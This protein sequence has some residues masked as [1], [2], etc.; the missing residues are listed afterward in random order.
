MNMRIANNRQYSLPTLTSPLTHRF[1]YV[2]FSA[3][4]H[5]PSM[6]ECVLQTNIKLI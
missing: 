2:N 1:Q 4:A 6:S 3:C 5:Q